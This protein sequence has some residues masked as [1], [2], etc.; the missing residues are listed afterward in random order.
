[1]PS[2]G[3]GFDI[4]LLFLYSDP[5][6]GSG[7]SS[8]EKHISVLMGVVRFLLRGATTFKLLRDL[9]IFNQ[10]HKK[11]ILLKERWYVP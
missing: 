5:D 7:D 6:P 9:F 11:A 3:G 2:S 1:M 10:T 4:T 8:D